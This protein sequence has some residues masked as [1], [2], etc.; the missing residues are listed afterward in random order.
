MHALNHNL[1]YA[2]KVTCPLLYTSEI[3]GTSLRRGAA[4]TMGSEVSMQS[5]ALKTGHD[6]RGARESAVWEYIDGDDLLLSHASVALAG[7]PNPTSPIYPPLALIC[8]E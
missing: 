1:Y 5:V 6:M 2:P 8:H 3:T 4:R 7:W